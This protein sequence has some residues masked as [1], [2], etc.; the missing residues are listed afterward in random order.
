MLHEPGLDTDL[1]P[2]ALIELDA[3][4][5]VQVMNTGAESIIGQSRRAGSGRKLS[6]LLYH[7]C[8]LF[9][10]IDRAE[11]TQSA[12]SAG[13]IIL[14][15]PA[16]PSRSAQH[17]SV[18]I[19]PG[20]GFSIALIQTASG[21]TPG[22]APQGLAAFGRILGHEVKNPLAGV[23]GA[24]Q[25]LLRN[26][27]EDQTELLDLIL[28]ESR[29][30]AR[31]VDKLSAFE[32]F[33]APRRL[34]SNVHQI[35]D[36]VVRAEEIAFGGTVRFVRSFDPS[37]PD[38][39][40][41]ADHLHEALQNIIRNA[42]EAI[43]DSGIGGVVT[44]S[45]RFS[46]DRRISRDKEAGAGRSLLIKISDN[47]PGINPADQKRIFDMFKTT[48]PRGSGL[49]LTVAGQ[50]VRAHDGMLHLES[51]PGDT[52]FYIYLPMARG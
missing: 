31:L 28:A 35:L 16:L 2:V 4:R 41:D 13:D 27:R 19:K 29:R 14:E 52:R 15:G 36:Q 46:L 40:V 48:K 20:G 51:T 30:I 38:I 3:I 34:P 45:T 33:S 9:D 11:E 43:R 25:L 23:S 5:R 24:A 22:N 10:L 6:E 21:G 1:S 49:G 17:A 8:A 47:G 50:V 18:T 7:D 39:M 37:L 12:V 26:A 44:V 42:G 32:L